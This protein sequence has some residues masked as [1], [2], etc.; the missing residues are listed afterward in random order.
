MRACLGTHAVNTEC[1]AWPYTPQPAGQESNSEAQVF[2]HSSR[3]VRWGDVVFIQ[4]LDRK[5][6]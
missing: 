6:M 5:N 2:V 1:S 4:D 3:N